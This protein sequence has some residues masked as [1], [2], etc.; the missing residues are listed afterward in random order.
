MLT[1]LMKRSLSVRLGPFV[2]Y[3]V[4]G[5]FYWDKRKGCFVPTET[6]SYW[7]WRSTYY[8]G[9]TFQIIF[10]TNLLYKNLG[11]TDIP[12][13]CQQNISNSE[14]DRI[15][16]ITI[17]GLNIWFMMTGIVGMGSVM[18]EYLDD[19]VGCM[20]Q[21]F[22]TGDEITKRL[23]GD[24][25]DLP[26]ANNINIKRREQL[27]VFICTVPF[28]V[29]PALSLCLF[30][31]DNPFRNMLE[32]ILEVQVTF[33]TMHGLG[34]LVVEFFGI[35]GFIGIAVT[36][37]L[38][39]T[40]IVFVG[41]LWMDAAMPRGNRIM[42]RGSVLL[43]TGGMGYIPEQLVVT[44]YRQMQ[45]LTRSGNIFLGT[46]RLSYHAM[47]TL[48]IT[49]LS[50][51]AIIRHNIL[52]IQDGSITSYALGGLMVIALILVLIIYCLE[53]FL[54][55]GLDNKWRLFKQRMLEGSGRKTSAH[56]SAISF[57]KVTLETAGSFCNVNR[58]TAVD[59]MDTA[60]NRLVDILVGT[61]HAGS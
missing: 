43:E 59:W 27:T 19:V 48:G 55:D 39:V 53:C 38:I 31:P 12:E 6:Y 33:E 18:V 26:I 50:A 7:C 4:C 46:V 58:S 15:L 57:Q 10:I 40:L 42:S 56:K 61:R 34:F 9:Q 14:T 16:L 54:I 29:V 30:H 60:I 36:A 47:A 13:E 11:P 49:V 20:N 21:I 41:E 22:V 44:L 8:V 28:V 1:P 52:L 35:L 37:S 5:G 32:D 17:V 45:L 23:Q 3:L 24:N 2:K 25:I 51:F